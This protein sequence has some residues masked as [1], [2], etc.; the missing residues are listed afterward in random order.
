MSSCLFNKLLL[1]FHQLNKLH[2]SLYKQAFT[3]QPV[4]GFLLV[5]LALVASTLKRQAFLFFFFHVCALRGASWSQ[6]FLAETV[7]IGD[8]NRDVTENI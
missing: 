3:D 8:K 6:A 1:A 2:I 5:E 7:E 4:I